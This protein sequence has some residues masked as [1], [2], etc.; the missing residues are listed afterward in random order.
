MFLK[1]RLCAL[2]YCC[3]FLISSELELN[4]ALLLL[5]HKLLK[6]QSEHLD[7]LKSLMAVLTENILKYNS[8][9]RDQ[10]VAIFEHRKCARAYCRKLAG[11]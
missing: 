2:L 4:I 3:C 8:P 9:E 6:E 7:L 1:P 5:S 11:D 10:K